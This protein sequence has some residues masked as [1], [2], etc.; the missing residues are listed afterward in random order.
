MKILVI[1]GPNIN[2]LGVREPALYGKNT[3]GELIAKIKRECKASGV[4]VAF[5]QSNRE[6]DLV[7]AIQ[8]ARGRYDGI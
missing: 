2:M 1:N 4:K 5:Y 3:Y 7:T 8:K 6:G